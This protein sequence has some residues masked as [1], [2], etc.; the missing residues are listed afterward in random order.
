MAG[1]GTLTWRGS[2]P[3]LTWLA[4]AL[5]LLL[6]GWAKWRGDPLLA[7]GRG[8]IAGA[9]LSLRRRAPGGSVSLTEG[10]ISAADGR[11]IAFEHLAR[12]TDA[13]GQ[14]C[15]DTRE[16]EGADCWLES[17]DG[18]AVFIAAG[19]APDRRA[20]LSSLSRWLEKNDPP[21]PEELQAWMREQGGQHGSLAVRAA[22][23]V[24]HRVIQER[25]SAPWTLELLAI[26]AASLI[27]SWLLHDFSGG[28]GWILVPLIGAGL[29]LLWKFL[30]SRC[31]WR[32]A[33]G[34]LA[35]SPDGVRILGGGKDL[36]L[37]WSE[38]RGFSVNRF[39]GITLDTA[40]GP[41]W[42]P[43]VFTERLA[44]LDSHITAHISRG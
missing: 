26:S 7:T 4:L 37:R 23:V 42:L 29:L 5:S 22:A 19:A 9:L 44:E 3:R 15:R 12:V 6:M 39:R 33:P 31:P 28:L 18:T 11:H 32:S 35:L 14:R 38:V 17:T 21:V 20:W 8:L 36:T 30:T 34:G 41:V 13:R 2:W 25:S 16:S 1:D 24:P 10:G 40:Q 43:P 27:I